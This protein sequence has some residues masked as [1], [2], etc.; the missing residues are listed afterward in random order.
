MGKVGPKQSEL[1]MKTKRKSVF[2]YILGEGEGR[3][4]DKFFNPR[5]QR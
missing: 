1:K 3:G 5:M 4:R 2:N